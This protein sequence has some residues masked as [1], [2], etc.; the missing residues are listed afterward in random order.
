[1][2]FF[3]NSI[4]AVFRSRPNRFIVHCLVNNRL[5]R[6]YLPNPG[7]LHELF[8]PDAKLFLVQQELSQ[9]RKIPYLVVAVERDGLPIML[10]T[11]ANNL[12]AR[13]LV[14]RNKVP[15]LEGA[16]VLKAEHAVGHSRFDFLLRHENRDVVL[17]VKSCTLFGNGIAMFPD[18]VT[19][20]GKRH[21]LELAGLADSGKATAVLFVVHSPKPRYFMPDYH[22]D[23][24]FSRTLL[25]VKDRIMIKALAVEWKRDLSFGS[26]VRELM[27]P[28]EAIERE[29]QDR[30]SYIVV[31]HCAQDRRITVGDLGPIRFPKGF[32]CYVGSAP[33]SLSKRVARHQHKR[34]R[35]FSHIDHLREAATVTAV[36]PVRASRDLACSIADALQA[37]ADRSIPGF[38]SADCSCSSHLF[39]MAEDPLQ[40]PEFIKALLY[41]RMDRLGEELDAGV[42]GVEAED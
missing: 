1:M 18:A 2:I 34:K 11:H 19:E 29:A 42:T 6:A 14:E 17:E 7:R 5:V 33:E 4:T 24:E 23:L 9:G 27:I 25:A 28:W 3:P 26:S 20:R 41:F 31:L 22:T 37:F 15:G 12:V 35:L 39:G 38:G 8:L 36:L 30:G 32:Y 13:H 21:L 10:H 16:V 40:S